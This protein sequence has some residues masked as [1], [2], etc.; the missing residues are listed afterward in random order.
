VNLKRLGYE[1]QITDKAKGTFELKGY[2]DKQ[3]ERFSSRRNE[4]KAELAK[5]L[6]P[7]SAKAAESAALNTRQ[8]KQSLGAGE[9]DKL[10]QTWKAQAKASG[11]RQAK[12]GKKA[13]RPIAADLREKRGRQIVS[14]ALSDMS[15]GRTTFTPQ[16]LRGRSMQQSVGSGLKPADVQRS[17]DRAMSSAK[18]IRMDNGRLATRQS[19]SK[20]SRNNLA[21]S[22]G[23][24]LVPA[25]IRQAVGIAKAAQGMISAAANNQAVSVKSLIPMPKPLRLIGKLLPKL[26]KSNEK[27][28]GMSR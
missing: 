13:S 16:Q 22:L 5:A 12:T 19:L 21:R 14:N 9:K 24:Q 23:W 6:H 7:E 26:S 11:I 20:G 2:S 1:V 10:K 4:I 15:K 17:L 8:R 25:P 3:L 27:S 28:G 18:V